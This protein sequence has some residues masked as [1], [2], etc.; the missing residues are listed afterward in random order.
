ME[1]NDNKKETWMKKFAVFSTPRAAAPA[2]VTVA[3]VAVIFLFQ[4][5]FLIVTCLRFFIILFFFS[6]N[7]IIEWSEDEIKAQRE[8]GEIERNEMRPVHEVDASN[9]LK[10]LTD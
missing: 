7:I 2:V 9:V 8:K 10:Q 1:E 6:L 3:V 4:T 5:T